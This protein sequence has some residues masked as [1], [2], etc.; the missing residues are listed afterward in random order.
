MEEEDEYNEENDSDNS[1]VHRRYMDGNFDPYQEFES[2]TYSYKPKQPTMPTMPSE[3]EM[4]KP[5]ILYLD[6]LNKVNSTNMQ[7]LR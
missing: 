3:A 7:C 2:P 4:E 5:F 6:S 1:D